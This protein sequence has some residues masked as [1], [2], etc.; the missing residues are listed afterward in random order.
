MN[1]QPPETVDLKKIDTKLIWERATKMKIY[2]SSLKYKPSLDIVIRHHRELYQ[3]Y[4]AMFRAIY[5]G[6]DLDNIKNMLDR[7][8]KIQQGETTFKDESEDIGQKAYEKYIKPLQDK[9]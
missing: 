8:V 9:N 1:N 5:N 2:L 7:I 3:T 6:H 4:P